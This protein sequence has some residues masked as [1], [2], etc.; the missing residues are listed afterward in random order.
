MIEYIKKNWYRYF[1]V[2]LGCLIMGVALNVFYMPNKLISGGISGIAVLG[3][4]IA[5]L[6]MGITNLAC[7][8]PLFFLAYKCMNRDYTVVA[9]FGTLVF[10]FSLDFF[11]FLSEQ[12]VVQDMLLSCI[13]GGVL[14]GIGAACMYRVDGSS[15]GTD[16]IGA[17]IQKKYSVSI[18]T[19]GFIFNI[20]LLFVSVFY[21][22]IEPVLYTL[23]T[24]F[25]MTKTCN[26]FTIGFD[27]KKNIIIISNKSESI[28]E[29]I[30]KVVGRGVTYLHGEGAYTHQDREV[31]FVVVKLTQLA[32]IK[33]I[34]QRVD[35]T[36]FVIIH[37]VNDVFGRGFTLKPTGNK[38]PRPLPPCK[39]DV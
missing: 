39:K 10:S 18:S 29:E 32:K 8:I 17:I 1:M 16:I 37:D 9:L 36:A 15:G 23:L 6:P 31:L 12:R 22:G 20:F 24:F 26:A 38:L 28:A 7:N 5:G 34:C 14:Y 3:Y 27:F 2:A 30:I 11:H 19:T 33:N 35:P 4:Y 25:T 21:F 13:A